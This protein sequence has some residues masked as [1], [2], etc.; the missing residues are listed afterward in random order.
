MKTA[1]VFDVVLLS[2]RN[3]KGKCGVRGKGSE[4]Y[5]NRNI[6]YHVKKM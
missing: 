5:S 4:Y 3:T 6:L 2:E 1:S